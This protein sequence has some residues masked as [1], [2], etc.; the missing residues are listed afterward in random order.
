MCQKSYSMSIPFNIA[1]D[2]QPPTPSLM[3]FTFVLSDN[4]H[5]YSS[6]L[7]VLYDIHV[8]LLRFWQKFRPLDNSSCMA[9]RTHHTI[10]R[11]IN[12]NPLK[13]RKDIKPWCYRAKEYSPRING[14]ALSTHPEDIASARTWNLKFRLWLIRH[15][16]R[17]ASEVRPV[18]PPWLVD[19]PMT[20]AE[21]IYS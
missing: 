4:C 10:K 19:M 2:P 11:D 1:S 12:Q 5:F 6:S 14:W 15:K 16:T 21:G 8:F 20:K 7:R 18:A 3:Q 17:T 13:I 9:C